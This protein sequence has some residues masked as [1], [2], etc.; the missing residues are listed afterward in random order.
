MHALTKGAT[1]GITGILLEAIL[2]LQTTEVSIKA[3]LAIA[4]HFLTNPVGAHMIA[5]AGYYHLKVK[6]WK[7]TFI[8]EWER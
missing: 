1:L 6:F 8:E 3:F 7:N 5:R 2:S 4:F